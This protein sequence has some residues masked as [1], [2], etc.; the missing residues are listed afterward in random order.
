MAETASRV[1][2]RHGALDYRE[3]LIDD[4]NIESVRHFADASGAKD[5]EVT[6]LAYIIYES[7][8]HRDQVLEKAM[9]DPE[10]TCDQEN[11]VFDCKRMAYAGF[12]TLVSY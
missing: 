3:C 1:W 11:P 5:D 2:K 7:R 12:T 9:A 10:L 4:D 8:E 6:I